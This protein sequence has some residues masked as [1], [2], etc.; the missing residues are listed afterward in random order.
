MDEED[1]D[2]VPNN[3][4]VAFLRVKLDGKPSNISHRIGTTAA[5]KH[6]RKPDEY[7]CIPGGIRQYASFTNIRS[8]L[9]KLES[10]KGPNTTSMNYSLGNTLMIKSV[11]LFS[12]VSK[13]ICR[14]H[15]VYIFFGTFSRPWPSSMSAGPIRSSLDT[16]SQ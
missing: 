6:G 13:Y 11:N 7:G 14:G 10:A 4:P 15:Q 12:N 5:T 9:K 1:W 16:E 2:I 8:T 3:V